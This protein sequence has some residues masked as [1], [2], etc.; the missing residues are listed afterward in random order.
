MVYRNGDSKKK[1]LATAG[2]QTHDFWL[3]FQCSDHWAIAN[4]RIGKYSHVAVAYAQQIIHFVP[5]EYLSLSTEIQYST[6]QYSK[7]TLSLSHKSWRV[8][9]YN[10]RS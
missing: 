1:K 2:K 5:S 3:Y 4:H 9:T 6:V 7:Q 8:K 10:S